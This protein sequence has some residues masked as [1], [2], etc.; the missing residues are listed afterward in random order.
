[1]L[2]GNRI[3]DPKKL[4]AIGMLCLVL[5]VLWGNFPG[6]LGS[7]GPGWSH[8]LRG[9]L[10]GISIGLNLMSLRLAA[11]QRQNRCTVAVL[12]SDL[13]NANEDARATAGCWNRTKAG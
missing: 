6:L 9:L 12:T 2:L 13:L 10:F 3:L 1:M 11:R 5:A 8:F 7:L 4:L